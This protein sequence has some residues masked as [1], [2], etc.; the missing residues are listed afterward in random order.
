MLD[1]SRMALI[2]VLEVFDL[3]TNSN[4]MFL[5][6]SIFCSRSFWQL[7]PSSLPN[8]INFLLSN[9]TPVSTIPPPPSSPLKPDPE[10]QSFY[11]PGILNSLLGLWANI[12]SYVSVYNLTQFTNTRLIQKPHCY[13]QFALSLGKKA[14]I[15]CLFNFRKFDQP[16]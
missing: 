14:C 9:E 15:F 12:L 6:F 2:Q 8:L 3:R 10:G 5:N 1:R 7:I 13:G 4:F 11:C 16:V